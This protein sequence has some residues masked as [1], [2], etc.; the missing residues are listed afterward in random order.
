M[1]IGVKWTGILVGALA[2]FG[3]FGAQRDW[4]GIYLGSFPRVDGD[5]KRFVFEWNDSIWIAPTAGGEANRLTPEEAN[6][7]SPALSP[8]G[9][10]VAYTSTRD[11]GK[12]VFVMDLATK[13]VRR[14]SH[15][16]EFTQVMGWRPD[17]R[18]LVAV[19][20]RDHA[21]T[22][23]AN[24]VVF[25]DE[26]G[27]ET[28]PLENVPTQ[29]AALSPDGR[30]L[31]L[32]YR[33][34]DLYRKRRSGKCSRDE[35]IW[36]YDLKK[37]TFTRAATAAENAYSPCWRPDGKAFYYLGRKPGS[38]AAG[39][40]EYALDGG[41]DRE[42]VSFGD[43]AAF[44]PSVSRDGRTMVVRAGFDFWRL[45]PA[46]KA[47]KPQRIALRPEGYQA[48]S[49]FSRRRFFTTSWNFG[50]G[51]GD[52]TF[53]SNGLEAALTVGGGLYAMD[54]VVKTPRLV[55]DA[56][57][58]LVTQCEFA[59]DGKRLYFAVDKGDASEIRVARRDDEALPWWENASFA[60]ETL[61]AGEMVCKRLLLSPDGTRLA[62]SDQQGNLAVMDAK[63]GAP[64]IR[65]SSER[66]E[67]FCWSPDNRYL[68]AGLRDVDGNYE[69]WIVTAEG[70]KK[71]FNVSRNWKWDGEPAWS[72][73]GKILAWS[74]RRPESDR[75]EIFYVYL[76]PAVEASEKADAVTRPRRDILK[77]APKAETKKAPKAE[78]KK[79]DEK[80]TGDAKKEEEKKEETPS[81]KIVF[82]GLYDRIRRT[83]IAGDLPFFSH[84]S[85]TLAYRTGSVADTIHIPDRIRGE[86]LCGKYGFD[87]RWY[88]KENRIVWR[89]DNL[90]AHRDKTFAVNVY[91]E[92]DLP[93]YRELAF[94]TA[95]ARL[96]DRFYDRN[97][98]GVDWKAVREK[99]LP[100]ARNASGYSVFIRVISL[101]MGEL[102]ASHLGF[103]ASDAAEREWIRTPKP[104]NWAAVTGHLG[105]RFAPGTFKVAEV[106]PG[107][108]AEGRLA[109]G[110]EILA[111]DG[112][113]FK[114]AAQL[115]ELLTLPDGRQVRL[116]V[117]G[118]EKEPVYLKLSSYKTIREL[119]DKENV[120]AVRAKVGK[121][122]GGRVGYLAVRRMNLDT[123][124][125][126]EDEI[127]SVAWDKDALILDVRD[128]VGGF[129]S[130]RMMSVLFGATFAH[131][132]APGGQVGYL[133]S[134]W[135]RPVFSK[136]VVVLINENVFSNG[137]MFGHTVKA[138][139]RGVLVGRQTAGGVIA[140]N[141]SNLLDYGTFRV[142]F[143]GWFLFDGTDLETNG[144]KPDIEVD[145]TPAD[146]E[147]GR[148]PQLDAAVKAALDAIAKP[149]PA[150][151][152]RYAK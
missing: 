99:Y 131:A 1:N 137:E 115:A 132:V 150:F 50:E 138:T 9:K 38:A 29:F 116:T 110:D 100:A 36:L 66:V 21:R 30:L 90:P 7:S 24:R 101:M 130:D 74:G 112:K 14:V 40:R 78:T 145:V 13:K 64:D 4:S 53:C 93:D 122:T 148:D 28:F 107:S 119:I 2:A 48:R 83:G 34:D 151:T 105:V 27:S 25:L 96:R 127:Y 3:A 111:V 5:G 54:T 98:H 128:N 41:S 85:R 77:E 149:A 135:N 91:R 49:S 140:T 114:N 6:E 52:V 11:G 82:D 121:A 69:V 42:V 63:G 88:A 71:R 117:K 37:K 70:E 84:D 73:D 109:T 33:Y 133:F 58:A 72:P 45:D 61:H 16:S 126:F 31:A 97:M 81:V 104:H 87:A 152:P 144:V 129:T 123:Y 57:R 68:A 17:G 47:P 76:D 23:R 80:K 108:N 106:I 89:V 65:V 120:K 62:F 124:K 44:Q 147:A 18:S 20:Q 22:E 95:W 141:E 12:K 125:T 146:L 92:D 94:R 60:V 136:P 79:G 19:A 26:E 143:L 35:E 8:D 55:F 134:Y 32:V 118:R 139:G 10:K 103:G 86:R 46:E 67:Q 59:P 142:P 15:N 51:S 113:T 75:E 39:V 102:N 56:P 43:D